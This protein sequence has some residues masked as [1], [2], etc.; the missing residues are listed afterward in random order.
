MT[1]YKL[2]EWI[3]SKIVIGGLFSTNIHKKCA[4]KKGD[5]MSIILYFNKT[6]DININLVAADI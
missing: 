3:Q 5:F 1:N 4:D 2:G 6:T